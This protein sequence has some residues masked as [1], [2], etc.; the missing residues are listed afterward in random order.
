M[1]EV[2]STFGASLSVVSAAQPTS[3]TVTVME[4]AAQMARI[5][6]FPLVVS[7]SFA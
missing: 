1:P 6:I 3:A 2:V 7:A 4:T 5:M